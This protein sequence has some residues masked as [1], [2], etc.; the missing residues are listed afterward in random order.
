MGLANNPSLF[1][2]TDKEFMGKPN[3][4]LDDEVIVKGGKRTGWIRFAVTDVSPLEPTDIRMV[5]LACY[6]SFGQFHEINGNDFGPDKPTVP[7]SSHI[8]S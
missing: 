6:D 8:E 5:S 3:L 7:P 4:I 1:D 2:Q